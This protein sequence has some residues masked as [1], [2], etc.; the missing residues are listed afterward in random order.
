MLNAAEQIDNF[1]NAA[2]ALGRELAEMLWGV[3]PALKTQAYE[4]RLRV[5]QAVALT[6]P[7]GQLFP[8]G[9]YRV[10]RRQ[11]ETAFLSL[12]GN[13][14]YSCQ[15]DIARGCITVGRGHRAG[16]CGTAVLENGRLKTIRDISSINL[17]I[18]KEVKGCADRCISLTLGDRLCSILIAGAPCSGKTTLLRDIACAL[19]GG[20]TVFGVKLPRR[21]IS[22]ID[23]RGE[24]A[25]VRN[26]ASNCD[27]GMCTDVLDG[28]P[29]SEGIINAVRYMSPELIIC[30]EI[31]TQQDI[32]ALKGCVGS[33]VKIIA[34]VH[35]GDK[36]ELC[37]R[38]QCRQLLETGVFE[39]VVLLEQGMPPG[40]IAEI[41]DVRHGLFQNNATSKMIV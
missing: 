23:E 21:R 37:L 27:I 17:R 24:L 3:S 6:L 19:S 26:G 22:V 41:V 20:R 30:D 29:R 11:M 15:E 2:A 16:I 4:V 34:S 38:P 13:A 40:R 35:C 25:A 8:F 31:G 28:Y 5:G 12:C 32:E 33:G 36:Q 10:D 1:D 7:S 9:E 14:V 39:K 18:A